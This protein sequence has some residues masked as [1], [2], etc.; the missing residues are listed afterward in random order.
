ME[1][2]AEEKDGV[3]EVGQGRKE[4]KMRGHRNTGKA[5]TKRPIDIY[6]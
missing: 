2:R 6:T 1:R 3:K 5:D 4:K